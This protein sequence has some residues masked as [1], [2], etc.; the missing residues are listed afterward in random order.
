MTNR[1]RNF[2]TYSLDDFHK[3]PK[4]LR[5]HEVIIS[6]EI[7]KL[8]W[9]PQDDIEEVGEKASGEGLDEIKKF[10]G[11]TGGLLKLK[12]NSPTNTKEDITREKEDTE[13]K[14]YY[15]L[16]CNAFRDPGVASYTRHQESPGHFAYGKK[17]FSYDFLINTAPDEDGQ[18]KGG[19]YFVKREK[20]S[21]FIWYRQTSPH[22]KE[23][24][25]VES[26]EARRQDH[27]TQYNHEIHRE[28]EI[29]IEDGTTSEV[30]LQID[31]IAKQKMRDY[32]LEAVRLGSSVSL[33]P[34]V[35][36][37]RLYGASGSHH[38]Q[39]MCFLV[40]ACFLLNCQSL[41]DSHCMQRDF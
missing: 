3:E 36:L 1:N 41:N 8:F 15:V 17:D 32:V 39:P 9:L 2:K 6:S 35:D 12:I 14:G 4:S 28:E 31:T 38:D 20:L 33:M 27:G 23:R 26:I 25:F 24:K 37:T 19:W 34:F 10:K 13:G 7:G 40:G 11:I 21:N 16:D 5:D 29:F 22:I 30:Q 18:K